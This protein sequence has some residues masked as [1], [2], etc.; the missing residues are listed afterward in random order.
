MTRKHLLILQQKT[1]QLLLLRCVC[2]FCVWLQLLSRFVQ[3]VLT[4]VATLRE[5]KRDVLDYLT[6]ACPVVICGAK[7]LSVLPDTSVASPLP[8]L[9]ST[10]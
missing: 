3:R 1:G 5:Q 6:E 8:E 9:P 2:Y 4:A 7:V 10:T